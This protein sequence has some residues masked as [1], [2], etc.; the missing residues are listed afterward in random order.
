M[1]VFL[2]LILPEID[3][4]C[5]K[6][7]RSGS[8]DTLAAC[9]LRI[10]DRNPLRFVPIQDGLGFMPGN[11]HGN[12]LRASRSHLVPDGLVPKIME[13]LYSKFGLLSSGF[14]GPVKPV[15]PHHMWLRCFDNNN[16]G[17]VCLTSRIE[18]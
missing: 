17:P 9:K 16:P 13:Q 8:R 3:E 15:D 7:C 12:L 18:C 2:L 1:K 6:L 5:P 4:L 11:Q 10:S 14:P